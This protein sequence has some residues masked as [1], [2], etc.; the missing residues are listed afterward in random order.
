M[1]NNHLVADANRN[2]VLSLSFEVRA[3]SRKVSSIFRLYSNTSEGLS[4]W[5][6]VLL[7][8]TA[9]TLTIKF[10][11]RALVHDQVDFKLPETAYRNWIQAYIFVRSSH[12]RISCRIGCTDEQTHRLD[13]ELNLDLLR[14]SVI[15]IGGNSESADAQFT[16]SDCVVIFIQHVML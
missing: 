13:N 1:T 2:G 10:V 7:D 9:S 11:N 12:A 3:G 8:S 4:T 15:E 14:D 16:V 5:F 6:Q